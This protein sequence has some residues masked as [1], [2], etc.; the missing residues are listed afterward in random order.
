M[1]QI[2]VP[3][4][5]ANLGCGFDCLGIGFQQ[6]NTFSFRPHFSYKIGESFAE[7]HRN[8]RNMV[9]TSLKTALKK[10]NKT[11][12]GV[13]IDI[14]ENIPI[15]RGL[16][17]SA[18]CIIAGVA[19]AY[20]LSDTPMD[21]QQAFDICSDLEGHADNISAAMFGGLTI[22]YKTKDGWQYLKQ[23][24]HEKYGFCVFVP[25]FRLS[26]SKARKVLPLNLSYQDG[27]H[28]IARSALMVT[29]LTQGRSEMLADAAD[30]RLHQPYRIPLIDEYRKIENFARGAGA[31][32]VFISGAGPSI[33]SI[34]D[35]E[36]IPAL[37]EKFK[38]AGRSFRRQWQAVA[39]DVDREGLR[40]VKE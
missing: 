24:P 18:T 32:A 19:A 28:N 29:A 37:L 35:T 7:R 25:N 9:L 40:I 11:I 14:E 10:I 20:I 21:M 16:G 22:S 15:S 36:N 31:H 6:Y 13:E 12:E 23:L 39:L 26:T 17:S 3:A 5:T 33:M 34:A 2:Q 27:I 8:D 4:S 30:D 1:L 38:K